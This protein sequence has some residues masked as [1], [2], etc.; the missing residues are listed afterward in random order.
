MKNQRLCGTELLPAGT[1]MQGLT[2]V[3]EVVPER[4]RVIFE[5]WRAGGERSFHGAPAEY[6]LGE[7]E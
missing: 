2:K 6:D 5:Y 7:I 1:E 3:A 4:E